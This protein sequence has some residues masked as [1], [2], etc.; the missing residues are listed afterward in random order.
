[1]ELPCGLTNLGNT[2]YMNATVQCLRSVPELKTAL[3]RWVSFFRPLIMQTD[4]S[5]ARAEIFLPLQV[6]RSPAIHRTKR[7]F[8]LYHSSSS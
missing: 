1:M 5:C 3:R 2:C 8:R 4:I 7:T 6:L